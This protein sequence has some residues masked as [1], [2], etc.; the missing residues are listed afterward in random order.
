MDINKIEMIII[1]PMGIRM[2]KQMYINKFE[3]GLMAPLE[4]IM[5]K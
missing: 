5:K 3:T 2:K 1:L 4:K